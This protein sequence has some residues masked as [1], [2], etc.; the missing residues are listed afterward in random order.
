VGFAVGDRVAET[1]PFMD[2]PA[3]RGFSLAANPVYTKLDKAW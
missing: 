2:P 3:G 1:D